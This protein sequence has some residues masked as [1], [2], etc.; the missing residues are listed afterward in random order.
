MSLMQDDQGKE[1]GREVR[2]SLHMLL[3]AV[4]VNSSRAKIKELAKQ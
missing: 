3:E 2:H 1:L 4:R